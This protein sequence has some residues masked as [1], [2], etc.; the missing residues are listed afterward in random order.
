MIAQ[1]IAIGPPSFQSNDFPSMETLILDRLAMG[2]QY[3]PQDLGTLAHLTVLESI[4]ALADIQADMQTSV[5]GVRLEGELRQLWDAAAAFEESV[6]AGAIDARTLVRI[7]PLYNEMLSRLSRCGSDLERVRRHVEPGRRSLARHHQA[8]RRGRHHDECDRVGPARRR[9]PAA[10]RAAD[11]DI[12]D[13]QTLLLANDV[14]ALDRK[15]EKVQ[16]PQLGMGRREGR[17]AGA[18]GPDSIFSKNTV[19]HRVRPTKSK[20]RCTRSGDGYGKPRP[21]SS[22]SAGPPISSAGGGTVRDRLNVISDGLGLPRVIDLATR[23]PAR[24]T[25]G[26]RITRKANDPDLS[27]TALSLAPGLIEILPEPAGIVSEKT[28]D[29]DLRQVFREALRPM[30]IDGVDKIGTSMSL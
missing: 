18:P 17:S 7:Q 26:S 6:S 9:S 8:H 22:S 2:G 10:R 1:I 30:I 5:L 15:R 28:I 4:A 21:G 24:K 3:D 12:L 27:R 14:L 23:S 11:S 13:R 29:T 25:T 20:H 16:T 19:R